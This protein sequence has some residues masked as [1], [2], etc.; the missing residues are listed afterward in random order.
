MNHLSLILYSFKEQN[1]IYISNT[2][3]HLLK[4]LPFCDMIGFDKYLKGALI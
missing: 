4:T 3:N 2:T 1:Q